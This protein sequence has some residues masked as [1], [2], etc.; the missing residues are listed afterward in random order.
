MPQVVMWVKC[1]GEE[2][3]LDMGHG[4]RVQVVGDDTCQVPG[5]GTL[6]D[7]IVFDKVDY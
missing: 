3:E 6:E 2:A 1:K 4:R 7:I 5:L